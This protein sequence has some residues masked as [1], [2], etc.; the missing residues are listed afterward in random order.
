MYM[1]FPESSSFRVLLQYRD[2][3]P[4]LQLFEHLQLE[5]HSTVL[6][7]HRG[8][9]VAATSTSEGNAFLWVGVRESRDGRSKRGM[10]MEGVCFQEL[11]H[12]SLGQH[13]WQAQLRSPTFY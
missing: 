7:G 12:M 6:L 3:F 11:C 13:R 5:P 8:P 1:Y 9:F 4:R 10:Y 2:A